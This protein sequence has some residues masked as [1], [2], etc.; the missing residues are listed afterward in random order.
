MDNLTSRTPINNDNTTTKK[1]S[2][3]NKMNIADDFYFKKDRDEFLEDEELRR[4]V[5]AIN[6]HDIYFSFPRY[7]Y[8]FIVHIFYY[9]VLS[10]FVVILT[11]IYGKTRMK[12]M[13]FWGIHFTSLF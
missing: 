8:Y 12:N 4:G 10:F 9:Y 13:G 1:P 6:G 3:K 11:P 2:K 7:I 5:R